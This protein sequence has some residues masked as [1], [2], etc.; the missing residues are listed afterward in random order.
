[1]LQL[2][3]F[4]AAKPFLDLAEVEDLA[5][6]VAC[7]LACLLTCFFGPSVEV[8]P[9][10]IAPISAQDHAAAAQM[11]AAAPSC[12]LTRLLAVLLCFLEFL[13][14]FH[15]FLVK[16]FLHLHKLL[17]DFLFCLKCFLRH[18]LSPG[19]SLLGYIL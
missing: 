1:M 16:L 15:K 7:L 5:E 4:P 11:G 18:L 12:L 8:P 19:Q 10:K 6:K 13:E 14:Y 2:L 3:H 17:D 9:P